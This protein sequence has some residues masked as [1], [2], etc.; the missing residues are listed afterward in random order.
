MNMNDR[1]KMIRTIREA[2]K[3]VIERLSYRVYKGQEY[4]CDGTLKK[5]V[6]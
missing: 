2:E 3:E 5:N 1:I 4:N 6:C